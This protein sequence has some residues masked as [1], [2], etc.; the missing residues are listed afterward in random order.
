[1]LSQYFCIFFSH[2]LSF[3]TRSA[4]R[5]RVSGW[6]WRRRVW[7]L[8]RYDFRRRW[9][10]SFL[11]HRR[12]PFRLLRF[13]LQSQRWPATA[14]GSWHAATRRREIP[15]QNFRLRLRSLRHL[16]RVVVIAR[17][18]KLGFN[19]INHACAFLRLRDKLSHHPSLIECM[20]KLVKKK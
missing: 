1:M 6:V 17:S 2:L 15:Q 19:R 16:A 10:S 13:R 14:T 18:Y 7:W 20:L 3:P 9:I 4:F 11:R 12:F 5:A 8:A